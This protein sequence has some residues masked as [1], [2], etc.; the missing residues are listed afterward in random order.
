M[1][2]ELLSE[3]QK[4]PIK[5]CALAT[6]SPTGLPQVAFMAYAV[7]DSGHLLLNTDIHTRK[8]KNINQN[9]HVALT[10]GWDTT[11]KNY[12]IQGDASVII[13]EDVAHKTYKE[14]FYGQN[15]HL[16][17][18]RNIPNHVFIRILPTW[19]RINDFTVRPALVREFQLH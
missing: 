9:A 17:A 15:P 13:E 8:V 19:V 11:K 1:E 5:L 18:F 2:K 7:L 4:L 3:L 10:V 6:A 16:E 14:I 12:Q